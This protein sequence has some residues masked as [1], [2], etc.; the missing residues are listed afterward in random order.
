MVEYTAVNG[1]TAVIGLLFIYNGYRLVRQGR[2]EIAIFVMSECIGVG[3]LVVA[4]FPDLFSVVGN[5]LGIQVKANAILIVSNLTLFVMVTYLF[6]R[7]GSLYD[8]ISRLNE[9]LTLL[10]ANVEESDDE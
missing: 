7:I 6:T 1:I 3:L 4:V 9:E 5:L 8:N 10:K 2:E